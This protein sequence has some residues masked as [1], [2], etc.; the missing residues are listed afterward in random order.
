MHKLLIILLVIL[1]L[2]AGCA[3]NIPTV[4]P[5]MEKFCQ[6]PVRPVIEQKD[7][8]TVQEILQVNLT[9]TDYVLKLESTCD[10]L[11]QK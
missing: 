2:M 11:E 9:I 8:W 4:V 6:R 3:S 10:C 1:I 5:P 7:V